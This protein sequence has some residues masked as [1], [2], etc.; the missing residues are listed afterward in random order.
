[1]TPKAIIFDLGGVVLSSPLAVMAQVQAEQG[2]AMS[3]VV[4]ILSNYADDGP[5]AQLERGEVEADEFCTLLDAQTAAKGVS[6]S[7]RRLLDAIATHLHIR[8]EMVAAIRHLRAHGFQVA[9]LTN[10]WNAGDG[11]AE[12]VSQLAP[13]FDVFVESY[14][15]HMRKP[16]PR[17]YR[18]VLKELNVAPESAVFLDDFGV[19]LKPA[20]EMGMATIRVGDP[21]KALQELEALCGLTFP[22]PE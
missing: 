3:T 2:E 8:P 22:P 10:N 1:M 17:I 19:N 21:T 6:F 12:R 18:H 16:E 14:R 11:F 13:E 5:W 4:S 7:A 9:A 15:V 20:R